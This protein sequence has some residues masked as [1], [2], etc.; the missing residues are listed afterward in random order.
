M[1]H[2]GATYAQRFEA[3]LISVRSNLISASFGTLNA[4][5]ELVLREPITFD[6]NMSSIYV[7]VSYNPFSYSNNKKVRHIAFQPE[8]RFRIPTSLGSAFAGFNALFAS[9]NVGGLDIPFNLVSSLKERRYQG[10]LYGIGLGAG[11]YLKLGASFGIEASLGAGYAYMEHEV[12]RCES[13]GFKLGNETR[14]YL[15]LTRAALSI[16]YVIKT[17]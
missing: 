1:A 7:P 11:Y 12:F 13:C 2:C 9:Y 15:G 6:D 5:V 16:A 10:Q 8:Y 17:Q 3:P 4:G 14:N